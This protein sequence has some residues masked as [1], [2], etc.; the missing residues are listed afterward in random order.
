MT[1]NS[2]KNIYVC[3]FKIGNIFFLYLRT[4]N[5]KKFAYKADNFFLLNRIDR[6]LNLDTMH[7]F[8]YITFIYACNMHVSKQK[9]GSIIYVCYTLGIKKCLKIEAYGIT[10]FFINPL[11]FGEWIS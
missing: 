2:L 5:T 7:S 9:I 3:K 8:T 6:L 4:E 11:S 10:L 1:L